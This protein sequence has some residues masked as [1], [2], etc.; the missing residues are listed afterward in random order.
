MNFICNKFK[1]SKYVLI[2]HSYDIYRVCFFD[3]RLKMRNFIVTNGINSY[4]IIQN[5]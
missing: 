5:R 3:N 1:N 2:F 4:Y